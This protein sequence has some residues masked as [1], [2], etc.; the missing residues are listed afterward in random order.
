MVVINYF[1]KEG[2]ELAEYNINGFMSDMLMS[3]KNFSITKYIMSDDILMTF[4]IPDIT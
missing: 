3:R 4:K 2:R 1:A